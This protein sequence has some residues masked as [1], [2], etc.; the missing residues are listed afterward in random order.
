MIKRQEMHGYGWIPRNV[1]LVREPLMNEYGRYGFTWR[2]A[3]NEDKV[4]YILSDPCNC[5][6][7]ACRGI[8]SIFDQNRFEEE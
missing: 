6:C 5:D 4:V 3:R 8:N 1:E 7:D 2:K